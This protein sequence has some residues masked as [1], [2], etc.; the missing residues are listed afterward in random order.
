M[1]TTKRKAVKK[2]ANKAEPVVKVTE[3]PASCPKC[4]STERTGKQQVMVRQISGT[5]PNGQPYTHVQ[6]YRAKCKGCG[7]RLAYNRYCYDPGS[8]GRVAS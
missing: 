8:D 7:Q 6:N 2:K 1:T 5:L 3:C 4:L